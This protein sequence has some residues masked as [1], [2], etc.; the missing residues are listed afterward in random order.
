MHNEP[1]SEAEYKAACDR[2]F[3][4]IPC[5][6]ISDPV[7]TLTMAAKWEHLGDREEDIA[8]ATI[9]TYWRTRLTD[10]LDV[11][12]ALPKTADGN[13][14][15]PG[16]TVYS[17]WTGAKPEKVGK[18]LARLEGY[19]EGEIVPKF[20]YSTAEAAMAAIKAGK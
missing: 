9:R 20:F 19:T 4:L 6:D 15:V 7:I 14:I 17:T 13:P 5:A 8:A 11:I 12:D 2:L 10:A 3:N 18:L 16:M 1:I